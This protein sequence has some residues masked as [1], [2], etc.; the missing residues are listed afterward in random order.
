MSRQSLILF[1]L[2]PLAKELSLNLFNRVF[3]STS[4]SFFDGIT[5][6]AAMM[7]PET[8]SAAI[9]A[10]SRVARNIVRMH[11]IMSLYSIH[12]IPWD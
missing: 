3:N 6:A 7:S 11:R 10:L 8:A 9:R 5:S 4:K 1:L 2:H 12:G